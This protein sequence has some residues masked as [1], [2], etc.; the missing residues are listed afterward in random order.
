MK[1]ESNFRELVK[2][3]WLVTW[4]EM[5]KSTWFAKIMQMGPPNLSKQEVFIYHQRL[6]HVWQKFVYA[7]HNLGLIG[8]EYQFNFIFVITFSTYLISVLDLD[9]AGTSSFHAWL[10]VSYEWQRQTTCYCYFSLMMGFS[11]RCAPVWELYKINHENIHFRFRTPTMQMCLL[12]AP[13]FWNQGVNTK[14]IMYLNVVYVL[15]L[16]CMIKLR[17]DL[18]SAYRDDHFDI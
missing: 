13:N 17:P 18:E 15:M 9:V 14:N 3:C 4:T 5:I 12:C 6:W 1:L 2:R 8:R 10:V 11:N 16:H 7:S